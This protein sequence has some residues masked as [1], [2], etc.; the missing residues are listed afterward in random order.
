MFPMY[1]RG[2]VHCYPLRYHNNLTDILQLCATKN[3]YSSNS[4]FKIALRVTYL[5]V[6]L[7]RFVTTPNN[8]QGVHKVRHRRHLD[9]EPK[10]IN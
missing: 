10:T 3:I 2:R 6:F 1:V 4:L 7:Y 9:F 8:I 5:N